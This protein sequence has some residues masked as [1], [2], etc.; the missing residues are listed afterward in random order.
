MKKSFFWHNFHRWSFSDDSPLWFQPYCQVLCTEVKSL[1]SLN[2]SSCWIW[3]LV[4]ASQH[5][6]EELFGLV[7]YFFCSVWQ[8]PEDWA[9]RQMWKGPPILQYNQNSVSKE[10]RGHGL[11][12]IHTVIHQFS[13]L[14]CFTKSLSRNSEVCHLLKWIFCGF[15]GLSSSEYKT[16]KKLFT[17]KK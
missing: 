6:V 3:H 15:L 9:K 10:N 11:I 8:F 2:G 4:Q 13:I 16:R 5:L 12:Q 14:V 1:P 17:L 7:K